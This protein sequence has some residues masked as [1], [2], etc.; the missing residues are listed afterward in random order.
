MVPVRAQAPEQETVLAQGQV[1]IQAQQRGQKQVQRQ[2]P[3]HGLHGYLSHCSADARSDEQDDKCS[4]THTQVTF[5]IH[6]QSPQ[7][8]H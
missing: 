6:S 7:T 5:T 1:P 3:A 8:D 4:Y 2:V